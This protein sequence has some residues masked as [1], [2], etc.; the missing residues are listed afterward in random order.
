ML[1]SVEQEALTLEVVRGRNACWRCWS[2]YNRT[3]Q[4]GGGGD[5]PLNGGREH[6][7]CSASGNVYI[8]TESCTEPKIVLNAFETP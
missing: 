5:V 8:G 2:P 3:A 4:E 1:V 7:G 6:R